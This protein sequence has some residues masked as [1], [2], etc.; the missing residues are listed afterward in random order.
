MRLKRSIVSSTTSQSWPLSLPFGTGLSAVPIARFLLS[1]IK[2]CPLF[3]SFAAFSTASYSGALLASRS[4]CDRLVPHF[5]KDSFT[6]RFMAHIAC[7]SRP[8]HEIV[9][10]LYEELRIS[11]INNWSDCR[12]RSSGYI[13]GSS[14]L[15]WD[16]QYCPTSCFLYVDSLMLDRSYCLTM[17]DLSNKALWKAAVIDGEIL[18]YHRAQ[19]NVTPEEGRVIVSSND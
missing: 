1:F 2:F 3:G 15:G 9:I 13:L 5:L 7:L 17:H 14:T 16:H 18:W 12:V 11:D 19:V 10:T 8:S 4:H 6:G